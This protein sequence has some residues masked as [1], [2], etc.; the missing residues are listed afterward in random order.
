MN[1][2]TPSNESSFAEDALEVVEDMASVFVL[3][4]GLLIIFLT[5]AFNLFIIIT[6]VVNK[7]MQNFTNIQFAFMSCADML[8]GT[9]AMPS[10]LVAIMYGRWPLGRHFCA[11]WSIGDFVGGNL[12]I[13]TLTIVSCHRLQC[14]KKPFA[15]KKTNTQA[16]LPSL[17]AW[18][19]VIV[20]WSVPILLINYKTNNYRFMNSNDCFFMYS[21]EYVLFADLVGYVL[22]VVLLVYFQM[23]IYISLK[24]K[25]KLINPK[26]NS[27]SSDGNRVSSL[28]LKCKTLSA[29]PAEFTKTTNI[30][31]EISGLGNDKN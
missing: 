22:P 7:Q 2:S 24:N 4:L 6:V 9:I 30:N 15:S 25:R 11:L 28:F 31:C 27:V 3:I 20:F 14:I 19:I 1:L 18:P 21:F 13:I 23:S 16:L 5:I 10:L 12:S 8:V 26:R 17:V 29:K